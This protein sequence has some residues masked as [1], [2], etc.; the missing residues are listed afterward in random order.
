MLEVEK[1]P[2]PSAAGRIRKIEKFIHFIG[3]KGVNVSLFYS[4]TS[5]PSVS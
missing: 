3:F 4:A 2:G 1:T 5:V